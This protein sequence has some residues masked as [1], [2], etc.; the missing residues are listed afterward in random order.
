MSEETHAHH[1]HA[2]GSSGNLLPYSILIAAL[3]LGGSMVWSANTLSA[4]LANLDVVANNTGG[5]TVPPAVVPDT[6]DPAPVAIS[7][8]DLE[9][10]SAML[11]DPNAPVTIVE[12]SDFQCPFC[13]RFVSDAYP[14]IKTNYVDTGKV[15]IVF[16]H[17]PLSFHPFA[18]KAS[19]AAECAR[20][21]SGDE[22]FWMMH[23]KMFANQSAI[24][25]PD[26]KRYAK[27]IGLNETQFNACLDNGDT[28]A[29]VQA[30]Y[31]TGTSLGVSG[32]PS[33]VIGSGDNGTPL[34]GAL[35]YA[36]F[37]SAIDAALANAN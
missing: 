24:D 15:K 21:L 35:P 31:T 8:Q 25:V 19:E 37:K 5:T 11:G 6:T 30:D 28:A 23:D 10:G 22:K 3:I 16:K 12:F 36:S 27:E 13:Q 4:G 9:G 7:V 17:F 33:F 1:S 34:V 20:T 32:T 18:Q 26:L 29:K 14:Q 2:S